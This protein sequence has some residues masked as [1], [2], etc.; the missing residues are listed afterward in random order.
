MIS[1]ESQ[2]TQI[3]LTGSGGASY[4]PC[5]GIIRLATQKS[6]FKNLRSVLIVLLAIASSA[7]AQKPKLSAL[8]RAHV[9]EA[10]HRLSDMGYWTGSVDGVFDPATRQALIAFQKWEGREITGQL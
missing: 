10:E 2:T 7:A 8:N 6:K 9:K 5:M 3:L 4:V 1:A